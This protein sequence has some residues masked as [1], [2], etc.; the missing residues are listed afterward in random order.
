M[1]EHAIKKLTDELG[2]KPSQYHKLIA[3]HLTKRINEDEGLAA[4]V[5]KE[6]KTFKG[7]FQYI[8]NN[9]RKK[10]V[11]GCA[12]IEDSVVYEWAEDYYRKADEPKPAAKPTEKPKKPAKK[13]STAGGQ[14]KKPV[15]KPESTGDGQLSLF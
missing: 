5:L 8:Q 6:S 2:E 7:C 12:A 11:G 10:A 14:T 15:A 13:P 4:D 9:A 1:K 3:A